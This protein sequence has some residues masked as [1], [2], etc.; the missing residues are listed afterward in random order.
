MRSCLLLLIKNLSMDKLWNMPLWLTL[1]KKLP[2]Q[3][4]KNS[5]QIHEHYVTYVPFIF[6][7]NL[8]TF[9]ICYEPMYFMYFYEPIEFF[10]L[11]MLLKFTILLKFSVYVS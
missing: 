3:C 1:D 7:M 6:V 10:Y 4:R 9:C 11:Y 8:C 2:M 5:H